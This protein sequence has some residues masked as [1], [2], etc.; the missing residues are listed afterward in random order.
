MGVKSRVGPRVQIERSPKN[1]V[2]A[3]VLHAAVHVSQ[4]P[5]DFIRPPRSCILKLRLIKYIGNQE[6]CEMSIVNLLQ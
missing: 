2:L 4:A 1:D 3:L 5:L 6:E